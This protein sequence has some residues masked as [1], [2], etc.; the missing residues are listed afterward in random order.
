MAVPKEREFKETD[1][2]CFGK[3]T[4]EM[5]AYQVGTEKNVADVIFRY[6]KH[7]SMTLTEEQLTKTLNRMSCPGE[8]HDYNHHRFFLLVHPFSGRVVGS[9]IFLLGLIV[10]PQQ[11]LRLH[12]YL[13]VNICPLVSRSICHS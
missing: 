12:P 11:C 5:R 7:Q 4:P 3:M 2:R 9:P 10:W 1:A 6:I 8:R 13:S